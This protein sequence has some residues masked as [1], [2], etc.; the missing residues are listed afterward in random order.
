MPQA[1]DIMT[2]SLATC[3]P[4]DTVAHA[5]RLMRDRNIGDVLVTDDGRLVGIVTDRDIALHHDH[6][7]H[8]AHSLKETSES[9]GTHRLHSVERSLLR[10]T[11]ALGLITGAVVALNLLKPGGKLWE[12]IQTDGIDDRILDLVQAGRTHS[13][14]DALPR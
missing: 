5:A 13:P 9:S 7:P 2:G 4:L 10:V 14:R 8:V 3:S 1:H 6:T 12:Q 11:L